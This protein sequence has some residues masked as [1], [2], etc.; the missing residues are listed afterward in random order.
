[1]GLEGRT[2]RLRDATD[3]AEYDRSGDEMASIGLHVVL[4]PWSAHV[5]SFS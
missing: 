4:G 1:M 5:L 3:G 2:W